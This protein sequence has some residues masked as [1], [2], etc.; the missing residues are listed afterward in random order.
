MALQ[1]L[2]NRAHVHE[3]RGHGEL[4]G[5]R[6]ELRGLAAES[7]DPRLEKIGETVSRLARDFQSEVVQ[8]RMAPLWHVF[9]R[10]PR[11]VREAS[12]RLGKMVDFVVE[13]DDIE[14]DRSILDE[15]A[16]P[17]LHLLRNAVDHGIERPSERRSC[18]KA[19]RAILRLS[20]QRE[21]SLVVVRVTDDGRGIDVARALARAR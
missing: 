20:V 9:D 12:R 18:G 4:E 13:G 16:D 8:A 2:A 19:D 6:G 21:R 14:L 17:L 15:L 11:A 10:F 1:H 3:V 5:V 7:A